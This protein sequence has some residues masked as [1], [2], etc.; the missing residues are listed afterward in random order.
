MA[1]IVPTTEEDIHLSVVRSVSELAWADAG[2][3]VAEPQVTR[4]C[5]EAQECIVMGRW[6]DLASLILTSADLV[7]SKVSEKDVECIYTVI[8]N[9]TTKSEN[10]DEVLEI[11]KLVTAKIT[12]QPSEKP[13]LRLKIL[14]NL[15]N[16]LEDG[17][18]RY[19]V[20]LKALQLSASGKVTEQVIPS[21]KKIDSFLKEWS[22]SVQ[23]Q[24][25]LYLTIF[26]ILRE[27]KSSGKESYN[28]V[29]KYLA[30]F[31]QEDENALSEVKDEAVN[32]II[33]FVKAPDM[34]QCDLLD[35][36]AVVQL[37][38]DTKYSP[39]YQLL[40][41]FL[42]QRLDAYLNFQTANSDMLKNYG[43]VHEDCVAKMRLLS[44]VDLASSE[45]GQIPYAVIKDTLRVNDNEVEQW[46]VKAISAKLLDC[47]MDQMN[48]VV[49]V[50]R[51]TERLFGHQQWV[52]LQSKLVTWRGNIA[53][54]VNTIQ[55]NKITDDAAHAMQSMTVR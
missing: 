51:R 30:T 50:S 10:P 13:V 25:E 29:A 22:V 16:L 55:A 11:V 7:F 42:T 2:A 46:V 3:E 37:E 49:I 4:L 31:S 19:Y 27:S 47:K 28:F 26:N 52:D 9:I 5:Q 33:E 48:Q 32:A 20:Y 36:P 1:T 18:S 53:N 54:V 21:L 41:I 24:R 45:S 35:M 40:L 8:C 15:Y 44:L 14:F 12:Q 34:F 6:L 23:D 43:L 39:I 17:Y 38:N